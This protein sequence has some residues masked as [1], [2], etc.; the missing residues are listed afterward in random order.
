MVLRFPP[1]V[2]YGMATGN[3]TTL[4]TSSSLWDGRP[5]VMVLPFPPQ[6]VHGTAAGNGTTL[7]TSSSLWDGH[8]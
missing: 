8:R 6:V 2:V 1:L 4:L 3:G 5:Q 7:P